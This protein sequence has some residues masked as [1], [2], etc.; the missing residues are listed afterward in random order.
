MPDI[1]VR[2]LLKVDGSVTVLGDAM[3]Q[4]RIRILLGAEGLEIVNLRNGMVMLVDDD[5]IKRGL[6]VNPIATEM[7]KRRCLPNTENKI[8]GDVVIVADSDFGGVH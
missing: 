6:P 1:V 4:I 5:G 7:Y 2:R 3:S 8:H